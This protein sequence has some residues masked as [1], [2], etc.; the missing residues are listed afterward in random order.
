MDKTGDT[1]SDATKDVSGG[2]DMLSVEIK[3]G[4]GIRIHQNGASGARE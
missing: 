1:G 2:C 3:R 4:C